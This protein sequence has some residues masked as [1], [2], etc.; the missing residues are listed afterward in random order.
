[1]PIEDRPSQFGR[2]RKFGR[3][4]LAMLQS[5]QGQYQSQLDPRNQAAITV[6]KASNNRPAVKG[7]VAQI[8]RRK[9]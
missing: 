7:N 3:A 4:G 8:R 5:C 9:E 2:L 1:M 6:S